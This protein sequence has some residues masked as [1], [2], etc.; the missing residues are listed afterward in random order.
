MSK[1]LVGKITTTQQLNM[2]RTA[3]RAIDIEL[4]ITSFKHKVH[5]SKKAYNRSETK[6][7]DY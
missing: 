4:G 5:K 6:K 7:I 3:R 2:E 1:T